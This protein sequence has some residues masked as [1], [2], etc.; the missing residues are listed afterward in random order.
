[1]EQSNRFFETG[2]LPYNINTDITAKDY[3]DQQNTD[4][5]NGLLFT[6]NKFNF[7]QDSFIIEEPLIVE[8]Y[9]E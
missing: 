5:E 4:I 1:M 9:V 6:L 7:V 2:S 3:S 8:T